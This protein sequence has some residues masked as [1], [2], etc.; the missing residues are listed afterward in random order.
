M[1]KRIIISSTV[2]TILGFTAFSFINKKESATDKLEIASSEVP[3]KIEETKTNRFPD[4]IYGI[5]PRFS[6]IKKSD[7]MYSKSINTFFDLEDITRMN[8]IKSVE[9]VII[10][11]DKQTDKASTGYGTIFNQNQ[12]EFIKSFD[13]S[14]NFVVKF[15]YHEKGQSI[16]KTSTPYYTIVP[17]IQAE[18]I[19]GKD[20]LIKYFKEKTKKL[21]ANIPEDKLKPAKLFFTVTKNGTINKIYL[22]STSG[23]PEID[24]LMINLISTTPG[25]W[26]PATNSEGE[27]VNQ[28]LVVSFGLMGC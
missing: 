11:N 23:Y 21:T 2:L 14:T 22:D 7:I 1:K 6:P 13:Y 8:T 17:E 26:I 12:I 10:E 15:D 3:A 19:F 18:Y 24:N 9:V 4:F 5:G 20:A 25:S 28:E 16:E 27:S